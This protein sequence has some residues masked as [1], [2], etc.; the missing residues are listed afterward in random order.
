MKTRCFVGTILWASFVAL[1]GGAADEPAG[2]GPISIRRFDVLPTH[3]PR[4]IR[5]I[6]K[7]P[8]TGASAGGGTVC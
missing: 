4:S 5:K 1:A 3:A 7:R 8:S 6:F 2:N